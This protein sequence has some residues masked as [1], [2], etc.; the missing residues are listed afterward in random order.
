VDLFAIEHTN[1]DSLILPGPDNIKGTGD[2]IHLP[3]RFN[4][5]AQFIPPG[6]QIA[7]SESYGLLSGIY[8]ADQSRGIGTLPGGIALYKNGVLVGGIGV[9]FPGQTGFATEENSSL[10]ST[11]N[12][13][14]PDRTLEAEFI[15]LAAAGG[16]SG[17]GFP[18]GT[19]GGIP[20]L[21][22]FDIP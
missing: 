15:G 10:G 20:A 3:S 4:V 6:V 22:G 18:V 7:A 19:L 17:A 1:R 21:P 8:P 5:P 11:F 16:S 9:F 2:D 14:K 12:P 13:T